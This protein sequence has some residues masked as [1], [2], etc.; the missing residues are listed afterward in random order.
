MQKQKRPRRVGPLPLLR[1]RSREPPPH[2]GSS[3]VVLYAEIILGRPRFTRPLS[4]GSSPHF[5]PAMRDSEV[6]AVSGSSESAWN[7]RLRRGRSSARAKPD[8]GAT[9]REEAHADPA[10]RETEPHELFEPTRSRDRNP[11]P[12][13][14]G[15]AGTAAPT[16]PGR[17]RRLAGSS[18]RSPRRSSEPAS[19]CHRDREATGTWGTS[20]AVRRQRKAR[21]HPAW[22]DGPH[23]SAAGRHEPA[24]ELGDAGSMA[25]L[26]DRA[27]VGRAEGDVA[28]ADVARRPQEPDLRSTAASETTK[29]Y[30]TGSRE[31]SA[32][33]FVR[34]ASAQGRVLAE[35]IDVSAAE[36]QTP[37]RPR[38]RR[39]A[40]WY[41]HR[42]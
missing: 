42:G 24:T 22:T 39:D 31:P 26:E 36:R 35:D 5:T 17:G 12:P 32:T 28:G 14:I 15:C 2:R 7:A 29:R 16:L 18:E 25:G 13:H 4:G 1:G 23:D 6:P 3:E 33:S 11:A 10:R 30:L 34:S 8:L 20:T 38:P 37:V 40:N 27:R 9:R 19:E 21:H 41:R